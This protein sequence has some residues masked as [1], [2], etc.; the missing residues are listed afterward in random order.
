MDRDQLNQEKIDAE[1]SKLSKYTEDKN[2]EILGYN[3]QVSL[4]SPSFINFSRFIE[5]ELP[6]HTNTLIC[7]SVFLSNCLI[8]CPPQLSGLQTK[9]DKAQSEAAHWESQW[10]HIKNTAASKTLE[11]GKIKM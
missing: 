11:L 5:C 7:Q 4:R 2:T 10:T 1:K 3:N 8:F 9:F 6:W